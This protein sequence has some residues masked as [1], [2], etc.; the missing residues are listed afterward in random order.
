VR[1]LH[2]SVAI[3]TALLFGAVAASAAPLAAHPTAPGA[4][5]KRGTTSATIAGK[6]VC[7][8]PG[9]SCKKALDKQYHRY[10]LHCHTGRLTR[11]KPAA[12]PTPTQPPLPGQ[13][14]DVG[15]YRLYIHCVGSGEPTV[16]FEGGSGTAEATRPAPGSADLHTA[17]AGS[18]RVCAYDRAGLGASEKRPSGVAATGKRYA[19]E[20]HALLA[21]ANIAPPYVLVGPSYG[22]YIAM[23]YALSY[24][25]E[26]AGLVFVDSVAACVCNG[27]EVEP[28]QFE[29]AGVTFGARPVVVLRATL[30]DGRDLAS[31]SS[32]S[33]RVNADSS[34]FVAQERPQLVIAA[35]RLVVDAVRGGAALPACDQT[36]LPSA[37]GICE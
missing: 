31:R 37:G 18:T 21:G 13:R 27:D 29:L 10:K 33:I 2:A 17:V 12:P 8:A 30:T 19:D 1:R 11:P 28:A 5:C 36:P 35:T 34:H 26:T 9:Q 32:N 14:V 3:S 25:A 4:P 16:V 15:G 23:S 24:P 6:H 22:G 7:L 20:L